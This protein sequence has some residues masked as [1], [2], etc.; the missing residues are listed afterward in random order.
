MNQKKIGELI[1]AARRE[2]GFTQ[3]ELADKMNISDKTVSKWECGLGCPDLSLLPQ[4]SEILGL[5]LSALLDGQLPTRRVL[6]GNMKKL[7]FYICPICGNL[8]TASGKA[9]VSCC[10]KKLLPLTP[11]KASDD[12]TVTLE[13]LEN[14][15]HVISDHP[16]TKDHSID[17]P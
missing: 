10:G 16:M 15:W 7:L 4:L 14:E 1:R 3:Q 11:Q 6:A 2:H 13:K 9:Q 17:D 5:D 8:I 12:Q